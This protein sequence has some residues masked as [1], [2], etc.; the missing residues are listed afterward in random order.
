VA[1]L[2]A[3]GRSGGAIAI[4]AHVGV[5]GE[6]RAPFAA[7]KQYATRGASVIPP[8]DGDKAPNALRPGSDQ[9]HTRGHN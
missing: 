8:R 9:T 6:V 3:V 7:S 4:D 5:F 1:S 2:A